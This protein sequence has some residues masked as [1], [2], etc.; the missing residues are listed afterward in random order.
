MFERPLFTP[1]VL[2][3][4]LV[5]SGWLMTSKIAPT[6]TAGAPP[7]PVVDR[8]D[9][10]VPVAWTVR[11]N[12]STLGWALAESR[13][14]PGGGVLVENRLHF[15]NLRLDEIVPALTSPLLRNLMPTAGTVSFD[16]WGRI[17]LEPSGH[18]RSFVSMVS[19][20]GSKDPLLL[21]GTVAG[22]TVH[23][24]AKAGD[25][26]Y[27]TSRRLPQQLVISDAL[28]PQATMPGLYEGRRWMQPVINPLRAANAAIEVLHAVVEP[29]ETLYWDGQLMQTHVVAFRRDPTGDGEPGC[30]LWVD[31]SGRVLRQEATLLN[32]RL[33][34]ERRSDAAAAALAAAIA[35]R[36]TEDPPP[37]VSPE[38]QP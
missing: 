15:E 21:N 20:P 5:T 13:R 23:I 25:L 28:T 24:H 9:R 22:D 3:F 33:T 18:L 19:I 14:T 31:R 2:V 29:E 8:D 11:W 10:P 30:R 27:D 36:R 34:F 32:A 17:N 1:I 7:V 12:A 35:T 6:W 4:W 26:V 38:T 16:A 37:T